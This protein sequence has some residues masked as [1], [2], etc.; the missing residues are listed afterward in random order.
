MRHFLIFMAA[1]IAGCAIADYVMHLE[2]DAWRMAW[3]YA[4]GVIGNHF[5]DNDG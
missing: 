2:A 1:W 3:G 4:V 5:A